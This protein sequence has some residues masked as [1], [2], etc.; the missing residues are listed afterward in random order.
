M[1][2]EGEQNERQKRAGM[3]ENKSE[4]QKINPAAAQLPGRILLDDMASIG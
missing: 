2:E 4:W 3:A 1:R